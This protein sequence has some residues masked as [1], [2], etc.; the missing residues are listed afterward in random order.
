MIRPLVLP[1]CLPHKGAFGLQTD[2]ARAKKQL[3]SAMMMNL[4]SRLIVFEDIGRYSE[5]PAIP[6]LC[7]SWYPPLLHQG[8]YWGKARSLVPKNCTTK[9]VIP[10]YIWRCRGAGS[11]PPIEHQF[12]FCIEGV[13]SRDVQRAGERM[14][15]CGNPALAALG[16]LTNVPSMTEVTKALSNRGHLPKKSQFS[17]FR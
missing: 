9:L 11:P 16:D 8:R 1:C 15:G 2:L 17:P 6:N 3:Q 4:E 5:G 10:V 13:T 7:V 14:M 12:L